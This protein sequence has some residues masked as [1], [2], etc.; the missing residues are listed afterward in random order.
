[1]ESTLQAGHIFGADGAFSTIRS[2]LQRRTRFDYCQ[3]YSSQAYKELAMPPTQSGDWPLQP[4]ALHIWPRGQH[5]LIAFPNMDQSFTCSLHM[6]YEGKISYASVRSDQDVVQLFHSSFP[7]VIDLIPGLAEEYMSHPHNAMV[8]IRCNPWVIEDKFVLIGDAAHAIY[9]SYGQGTNAGSEDCRILFE[10][11]AE[12]NHNWG[13]ALADYQ[14]LRKPNADAIADLSERH[15]V[16]LRDLVGDQY[17]LLRKEVE[18][19]I[20][21]LYPDKFQDLYSMITFSTMPYVDALDID[22]QQ[23]VLVDRLMAAED[24]ERRWHSGESDNLIHEMMNS[25]PCEPISL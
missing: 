19:R 23:R 7:D 10:A 4:N 3:T 16:E 21:K 5:M 17:F 8:T 1:V 9:P 14:R 18:R 25:Q 15:F 12:H 20:N 24:F 22:R 11:L 13:A 6:P 2:F